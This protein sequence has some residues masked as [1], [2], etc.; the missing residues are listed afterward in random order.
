MWNAF[1][2]LFYF[3]ATG[4]GAGGGGALL[5]LMLPATYFDFLTWGAVSVA[6]AKATVASISI[7]KVCSNYRQILQEIAQLA[8]LEGTGRPSIIGKM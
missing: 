3:L 6:Q 4:D 8:E 5:C 1:P 7:A 2:F